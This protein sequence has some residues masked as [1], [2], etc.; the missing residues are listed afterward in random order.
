MEIEEALAVFVVSAFAGAVQAAMGLGFSLL[1]MPPLV[2]MGDA[3]DAVVLS[4]MRCTVLS[5]GVLLRAHAHVE[6]A[7]FRLLVIGAGLGMPAGFLVLVVLPSDV[8]QVVIALAVAACTVALVRGLRTT[9]P[10]WRGDG[11]AGAISGFAR[12]STGIYGPPVAI[13]LQARG[14]APPVFRST[15][16]AF[17]AVTGAMAVLVFAAAGWVDGGVAP[18]LA[19]GVPGLA[20]GLVAGSAVFRAI[21]EA[22]FRRAVLGLL[23]ASVVA[24]MVS[25]PLG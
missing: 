13:H 24:A 25:V 14:T 22:L 4:N 5:A 21:G 1:L 11:L 2:L 20:V 10:G 15:M 17:V 18:G 3:R 19:A 7:T 9:L 23:L 6:W 8:L 12:A 16:T